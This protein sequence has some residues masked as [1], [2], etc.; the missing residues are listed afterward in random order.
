MFIDFFFKRKR[1]KHLSVPIHAPIGDKPTTW[2][3]A[4][5]GNWTCNLLVYGTTL[6]LSHPARMEQVTLKDVK[7]IRSWAKAEPC[8][9]RSFSFS[10]Y[11]RS[12][13]SI[14]VCAF[15]AILLALREGNQFQSHLTKMED[16]FSWK[17]PIQVFKN[18]F[19]MHFLIFCF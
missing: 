12:H 14:K 16:V 6:Q 5:T 2:V 7:W 15:I 10:L 9:Q 8:L 18:L 13:F 17:M 1:E 4:Q 11:A 19:Q 3:C